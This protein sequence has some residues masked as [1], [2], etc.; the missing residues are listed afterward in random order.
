MTYKLLGEIEENP[1][2][3]SSVALLS[4]ACSAIL[5]VFESMHI[6]FD[7]PY[8]ILLLQI[9]IVSEFSKCY[10]FGEK[11]VFFTL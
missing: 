5:F 3:I 7:M 1:E 2:E 10:F 9:Y 8:I 11:E 6:L 4:P